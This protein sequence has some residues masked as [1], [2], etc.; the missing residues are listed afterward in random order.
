MSAHPHTKSERGTLDGDDSTKRKLDLA[1]EFKHIRTGVW[2]IYEQIPHSR[3]GFNV[4]W[5]PGLAPNLDVFGDLSF[6]WRM[7]KDVIKIK[8]CRYYLC[9]F[10]LVKIL[11]S[12]QPAVALWCVNLPNYVQNL[13]NIQCAGSPVTSSPLFVSSQLLLATFNRSLRYKWR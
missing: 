1:K 9:L 7:V 8:S 2:D 11:L 10:I 4:P 13:S 3:I 5:I 6:F 12:L